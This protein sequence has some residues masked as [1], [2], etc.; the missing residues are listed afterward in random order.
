M[1]K[2]KTKQ[3]G[4][5]DKILSQELGVSR[6][7]VEK[8][9]ERGLVS[10][11]DKVITKGSYK[12]GEGDI[13]SYIFK[14]ATKKEALDIDFD[15]EIL[16]EDDYLLVINK[17]S[18]LVVHPAP[19]VKE[20]T[21]VD[22]LIHKG[23]SLSTISGEERHGIVHRIDK[24]TTGALVI[25]KDNDTHEKLSNQLKDK[26]MGRYYLAFIDCPL[27]DD[28]IVDKPIA[29]NPKNRLK[30]GIVEGG[31]EAKT[32]F[33][34]LLSNSWGE[35][36]IVAKLFTGRT[37]QI[38]VHL[39]FLGR[40]IL[41][42]SLYGFKSKRGKIGRVNLHAYLLYLI[43]PQS[44]QRVE[45]I[46]PLFDDMKLYLSKNFNQGEVNEKINPNTLDTLFNSL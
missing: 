13:I 1:N 29:R 7:Q 22:W 30:M 24:E 21:L 43:H 31:R 20:P 37:H 25:A 11:G 44:G 16:Y 23:I 6:N 4:R 12:V 3:S 9:I 15:V 5:I 39:N 36:L 46:A 2:I 38:R 19:S 27:K 34:K 10:I 41:G 45:F 40:H 33:V 17:P 14:E 35:E 32:A 18:G 28:V 8:L 26:S 42:D